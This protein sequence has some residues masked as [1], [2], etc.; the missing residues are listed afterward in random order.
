MMSCTGDG[1]APVGLAV[2][3]PCEEEQHILSDP[4]KLRD[5]EEEEGRSAQ[6]KASGKSDVSAVP[7]SET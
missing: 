4:T 2:L 7:V 5:D 3:P 6:R 1:P